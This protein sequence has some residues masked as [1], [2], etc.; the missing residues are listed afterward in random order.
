MITRQLAAWA[1]ILAVPTAIAGIYGMNFENMPE[2]KTQYGYF[3]VVGI[4]VLLP[5]FQARAMALMVVLLADRYPAH[6]AADVHAGSRLCENDFQCLRF[7]CG[8]MGI[9]PRVLSLKLTR[10]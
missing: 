10:Q 3:V 1:A 8:L 6:T 2:L 9:R 7:C 5:A 4:I